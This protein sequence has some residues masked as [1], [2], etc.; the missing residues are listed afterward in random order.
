MPNSSS[1]PK[2][3]TESKPFKWI[4]ADSQYSLPCRVDNGNTYVITH[5]LSLPEGDTLYV[6]AYKKPEFKAVVQ[7]NIKK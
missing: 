4:K 3:N 2:T 6:D 1:D 7:E 5:S